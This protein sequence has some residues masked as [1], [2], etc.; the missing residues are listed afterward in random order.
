MTCFIRFEY[1]EIGAGWPETQQEDTS[2]LR[3]YISRDMLVQKN[4]DPYPRYVEWMEEP[5]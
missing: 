4:E 2:W 5:S 1:E 3:T